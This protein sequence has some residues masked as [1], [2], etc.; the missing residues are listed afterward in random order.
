MRLLS[1]SNTDLHH[2]CGIGILCHVE[3]ARPEIAADGEGGSLR[4]ANP[5]STVAAWSR[6]PHALVLERDEVHVWRASLEQPDTRVDELFAVLDAE[7]RRRAAR[8]RF[9]KDQTHFVV[10]RG[11]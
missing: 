8:F 5:L 10:A 9:R 2:Y 11:I 1:S 6:P 4:Q 3:F 7:E